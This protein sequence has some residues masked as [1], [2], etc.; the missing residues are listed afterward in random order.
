MWPDVNLP[1]RMKRIVCAFAMAC[2]ICVT[3]DSSDDTTTI[4]IIFQDG[5][6]GYLE[7]HGPRIGGPLRPRFSAEEIVWRNS[8]FQVSV[9]Q[10]AHDGQRFASVH[11]VSIT[12]EFLGMQSVSLRVRIPA[13]RVDGVW[14]PS[15]RVPDNRFI[16]SDP[17]NNFLTYSAANYGIP[18]LAAATAGGSNLLAIGLLQQDS[19]VTLHASPSASG[20]YELEVRAAVPGNRTVLD[21]GFF[22]SN[23]SSYN[24]FEIARKYADR[25]EEHTQYSPFPISERSYI[26]VY[27]SWFW[28]KDAVNDKMYFKPAKAASETGLG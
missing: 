12:G 15:G 22:V 1:R 3:L 19:S 26:P 28:S 24:W 5:L 9:K 23:D 6:T 11:I 8:A 18:Y 20:F 13:A 4:P 2:L 25:S 27:D 14:T 10:N 17:D 16:S 7:L 21:R